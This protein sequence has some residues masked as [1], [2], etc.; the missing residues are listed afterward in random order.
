M[1]NYNTGK[2]YNNA[3][4]TEPPVFDPS[5][6]PL[7]EWYIGIQNIKEINN[8]TKQ[9]LLFNLMKADNIDIIIFT[10]T[11]F[12]KEK[13]KHMNKLQNKYE[14]FGTPAPENSKGLGYGVAIVL[15][16][17]IEIHIYG[18]SYYKY[19]S[20]SLKLSFKGNH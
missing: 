7:K 18:H 17:K 15:D 6:Y 11:N 14:I 12:T 2:N 5:I 9:V 20:I 19:Y 16:K 3:E 10:E 1:S 4:E 8:S 13:L